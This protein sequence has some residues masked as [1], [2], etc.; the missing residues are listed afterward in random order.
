MEP[1]TFQLRQKKVPPWAGVPSK[2]ESKEG[3][4]IGLAGLTMAWPVKGHCLL[5]GDH[6]GGAWE[7]ISIYKNH[8]QSCVLR[9]GAVCQYSSPVYRA[10]ARTQN[11]TILSSF[12]YACVYPP[13]TNNSWGNGWVTRGRR[14]LNKP[15]RPASRIKT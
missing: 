10:A 14:E 2:G 1:L 15:G 7:N 12:N 3:G 13:L 5:S 4:V 6:Q 8:R 9:L 11:C